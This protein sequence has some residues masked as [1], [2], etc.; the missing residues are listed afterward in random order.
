MTSMRTTAGDRKGTGGRAK[1]LLLVDDNKLLLESLALRIDKMGVSAC[2]E[3][4]FDYD[5]AAVS[6]R[7]AVTASRFLDRLKR[8]WPHFPN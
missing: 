7:E 1:N 5:A 2:F 3:K 6:I 4:P 8:R